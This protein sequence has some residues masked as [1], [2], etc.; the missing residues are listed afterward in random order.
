MLLS[1]KLLVHRLFTDLENRAWYKYC[2]P[3]GLYALA[4]VLIPWL[5]AAASIACAAGLYLGLFAAPV[6]P[7]QGEAARIVFIHVPASWVSTLI[8]LAMALSAGIG[9]AFNARLAAMAAQALAPTGLMFTFLDLWT[10]CLWGKAVSGDWWA[11]DLQTCSELVLALVFVGFIGLHTAIEDLHRTNTASALLLLV[12]ALSIL[13]NFAAVESWAIQ[14]QGALIGAMGATGANAVELSS[15]LA[16]SLG[17]L[18]YGGAAALL[19]LRC[20]ILETERQ[21]DWVARRGSSAP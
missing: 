2:S 17:F 4:G 12:G 13:V 20:V 15:L 8:Y 1:E 21:S 7:R 9:S 11:W 16:M 18:M 19:R 14:H 3:Q 10:G 5:A 6:D